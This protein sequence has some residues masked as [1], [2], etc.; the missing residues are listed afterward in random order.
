M[1]L[2]GRTRGSIEVYKGSEW[3]PMGGDWCGTGLDWV[4]IPAVAEKTFD[5]MA[6]RWI[7]F[8][9]AKYRFHITYVNL[10]DFHT[11]EALKEAAMAGRKIDHKPTHHISI[12]SEPLSLLGK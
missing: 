7:P 8:E 4:E 6:G 12:Y 3:V 1:G 5:V 11:L 10:E 9:A 2:I